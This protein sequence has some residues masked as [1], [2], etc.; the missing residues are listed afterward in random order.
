[1]SSFW[2]TGVDLS[3]T[4]PPRQILKAAQGEWLENSD[5][6]MDLILQDAKT[7]SG[8]SMIIVHAKHVT[9]NRTATLFSVVHRPN[10]P[11]PA[12]IQFKEE[13]LPSFLKKSYYQPDSE[14]LSQLGNIIGSPGKTVANEWVSVTPSEFRKK[15]ADAF[16]QGFVKSEV[17]NLASI[18]TEEYN[19]T[20]VDSLE[21]SVE[22]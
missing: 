9:S 7:K 16:N 14:A 4:Q 12:T 13:D 5:G 22:A 10:H 17:L 15:L 8:N 21:D 18:S 3:D 20:N 2:P 19:G 11:Y 6:I 1:M